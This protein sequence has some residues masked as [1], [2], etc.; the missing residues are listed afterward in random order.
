[1]S[2]AGEPCRGAA[3]N[4][5]RASDQNPLS[6]QHVW[7][8]AVTPSSVGSCLADWSRAARSD[9]IALISPY[10]KCG[11]LIDNTVRAGEH[12]RAIEVHFSRPRQRAR[13]ESGFASGAV[14]A[15]IGE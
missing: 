10:P 2:L 8:G 9:K 14:S 3:D 7:C 1:V 13:I 4:A 6:R 11:V 15:D 12:S 5:G